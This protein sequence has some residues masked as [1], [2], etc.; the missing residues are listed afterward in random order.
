MPALPVEHLAVEVMRGADA[1]AGVGDVTRPPPYQI[2][3]LRERSGRDLRI[4]HQASR[5]V[6][7][8]GDRRE[9]GDKVERSLLV[10]D[11]VNSLRQ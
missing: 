9:I 7:D 4:D 5:V 2:D 3:E 1:G 10:L 8:R 6:G 11:Q